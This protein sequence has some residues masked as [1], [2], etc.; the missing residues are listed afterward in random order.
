TLN[1]LQHATWDNNGGYSAIF[2]DLN[3][4][5][6]IDSLTFTASDNEYTV[7]SNPFAII[8]EPIDDLPEFYRIIMD[9]TIAEDTPLIYR[10]SDYFRDVD[11]G[12]STWFFDVHDGTP[13]SA[14][15]TGNDTIIIQPDL[16]VNELIDSIRIGRSSGDFEIHSNYFDINITPIND[17]PVFNGTIP[18]TTLPMGISDHSI[19]ASEYFTDIEGNPLTY[20]TNQPEGIAYVFDSWIEFYPNEGDTLDVIVTANDGELNTESNNF[21]IIRPAPAPADTFNVYF[22]MKDFKTDSVLVDSMSTWWVDGVEY[23]SE[24]GTLTL[25]LPE[26]EH[27]FNATN[28]NTIDGVGGLNFSGD[29]LFLQRPGDTENFEQRAGPDDISNIVIA[30][31]DT[32]YAYKIMNDFPLDDVAEYLNSEGNGTV[33]FGPDD[34]NAPAWWD[35]NYDL[36]DAWMSALIPYLLDNELSPATLGKLN[37]QYIESD[38]DPGNPK[39]HMYKDES[40]PGSGN[41]ATS[42]IDGVIYYCQA[43]WPSSPP[44]TIY[45]LWIEILQAVGDLPDLGGVDPPV[46]SY[47]AQDG[48]YINDFGKSTFSLLYFVL[49]DTYFD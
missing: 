38:V 43:K 44:P 48:Y 39:L 13:L 1:N 42:S 45:T 12:E 14:V 26:G 21:R 19:D 6:I 7:V 29:F 5:G 30:Q 28:P 47:D 31:N 24:D 34:L 36:P 2:P 11:G 46:I 27:S 40:V 41:N 16:N 8:V 18:D 4:F 9:T 20:I 10:L 49:P 15:F 25:D 22:V 17:A 35:T 37:M 32:I 23:T 3:W 33:R